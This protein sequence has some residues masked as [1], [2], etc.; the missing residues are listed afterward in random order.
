MSDLKLC[1][2]NQRK[3][4]MWPILKTKLLIYQSKAKLDKKFFSDPE[5]R[6]ILVKA[7]VSNL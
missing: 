7:Q 5:I 6:T 2:M 4:N 1:L 3:V